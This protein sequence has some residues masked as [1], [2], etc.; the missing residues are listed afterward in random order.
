MEL[1]S[2]SYQNKGK[3]KLVLGLTLI[4]LLPKLIG[5]ISYQQPCIVGRRGHMLTDVGGLAFA[6]IAI[7]IAQRTPTDKRTY[8]YYRQRFLAALANAV[9]LIFV[10]IYIRMK[11]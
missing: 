11:Q 9:I 7:N 3:L 2:A 10:S 4:Y 8:G 1:T 6:L 5:G